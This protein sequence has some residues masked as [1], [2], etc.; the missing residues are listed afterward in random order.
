[1]SQIQ[2]AGSLFSFLS[3]AAAQWAVDALPDT[4]VIEASENPESA[5]RELEA[6]W[7][8]EA[9]KIGEGAPEGVDEDDW[10]DAC[11]TALVRR[12]EASR[13]AALS[14]ERWVCQ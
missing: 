9:Q 13:K 4:S 1:M 7:W 2:Y 12:I 11:R 14:A 6:H 10:R 3:S 8:G 5:A